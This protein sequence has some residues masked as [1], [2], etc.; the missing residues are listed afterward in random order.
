[1]T[2]G[3]VARVEWSDHGWTIPLRISTSPFDPR[4]TL[5]V[6]RP[7]RAAAVGSAAGAPGLLSLSMEGLFEGSGACTRSSG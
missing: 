4:I 7:E 3:A 1:M 5:H 6:D 2:G